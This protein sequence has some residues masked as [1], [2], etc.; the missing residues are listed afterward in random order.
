MIESTYNSS[1][2]QTRQALLDV[3]SWAIFYI[4]V[5]CMPLL[6][7]I[8]LKSCAANHLQKIVMIRN[9]KFILANWSIL[10]QSSE[11]LLL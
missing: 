6:E 10:D 4:S 9:Y 5:E 1:L 11:L 8:L 2:S 7:N 3:W